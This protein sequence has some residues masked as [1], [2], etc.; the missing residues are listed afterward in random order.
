MKPILNRIK[1]NEEGTANRDLTAGYV[2]LRVTTKVAA[3][4]TFCKVR[5]RRW[6]VRCRTYIP[7]LSKSKFRLFITWV[8][9][10]VL[11][12]GDAPLQMYK[13]MTPLF[14]YVHILRLNRRTPPTA[15]Q[16]HLCSAVKRILRTYLQHRARPTTQT[17][18][19]LHHTHNITSP[20]VV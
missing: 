3:Y 1:V 4:S 12:G 11:R 7:Y 8:P 15:H 20:Q 16:L 18:C 10:F 9:D 13:G 17:K 14:F 19:P 6:E 5:E 2:L